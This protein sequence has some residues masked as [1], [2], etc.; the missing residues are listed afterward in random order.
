MTTTNPSQRPVATN[1]PTYYVCDYSK[2]SVSELWQSTT[3]NPFR[4]LYLAKLLVTKVSRQSVRGGVPSLHDNVKQIE[5]N[6]IP[7]NI[8]R[9]IDAPIRAFQSAGF[10]TRLAQTTTRS[11]GNFAYGVHLVSADRL[12]IA[13]VVFARAA[14]GHFTKSEIA[15]GIYTHRR[16]GQVIVTSNAP[17]RINSPT[18]MR[19]E[20]MVGATVDQL[21]ARH[22]KRI[23][24]C[25]DAIVVNETVISDHVL[26]QARRL[27]EFYINRGF[28]VPAN[29]EEK[30]RYREQIVAPGV[31]EIQ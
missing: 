19:V 15:S 11:K 24:D 10:S 12:S 18:E 17:P 26:A 22:R 30:S 31:F 5:F 16:N 14:V 9:E 1:F 28:H 4:L 3:L 7:E 23:L 8:M 6:E 2:L 29:A 21:V 27:R 20:R 25:A 13:G